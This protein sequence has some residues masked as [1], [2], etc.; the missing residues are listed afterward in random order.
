MKNRIDRTILTVC[1]ILLFAGI[2]YATQ[3]FSVFF[4][5]RTAATTPLG[6]GDKLIVLQGGSDKYIAGNLVATLADS[7]TLTN[8]T[9]NGSSNTLTVL[10]ASQLSGVVGP[11]NGGT[12]LSS[13]TS[14]GILCATGSTTYAFSS[15]P[16]ANTPMLWGGAGACPGGGTRSGNTTVFATASGALTSA[17][18][19]VADASGN[20]VSSTRAALLD[21]PQT[22][23]GAQTFS[24]TFGT[25]VNDATLNHNVA[26]GDC[27][28]YLYMTNAS[29]A[30]VTLLNTAVVGCSLPIE[31]GGAGQ[32]TVVP[33]GAGATLSNGHGYTK[34]FGANSVIN[35]YVDTNA[36]GSA[37]H[38]VLTGDGA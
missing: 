19:F 27:G 31:Q 2:S 32:I 11:A 17:I 8:K 4:A 35:V 28:K 37:A 16:A 10:A 24:S 6:S 14:G 5:A 22:W 25:Q 23:T 18:G 36:G 13:G 3:D 15:A 12:G 34:T 29:A 26:A 21:I 38:W 7:Q 9:I 1:L 20:I 30:T 33:G